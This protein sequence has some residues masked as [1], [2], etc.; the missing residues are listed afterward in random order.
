MFEGY[1]V[2]NASISN[3]IEDRLSDYMS[4]QYRA[5]LV[6][7]G[8]E[9]D[10]CSALTD[11]DHLDS[12]TGS[13][14]IEHHLHVGGT[15]CT[16][17]LNIETINV[18]QF[19]NSDSALNLNSNGISLY[20]G[21][22]NFITISQSNIAL[23]AGSNIID[24]SS[25]SISVTGNTIFNSPIKMAGPNE[26]YWWEQYVDYQSNVS[27][28][29]VFRSKGG[30]MVTFNDDFYPE[31]LNF[32]GKH[33]CVLKN[34]NI[35][36]EIKEYIGKIVCSSGDYSN[37][38]GESTIEIDEAIPVVE[39]SKTRM[40]KKIFG[41]IAGIDRQGCFRI[42]NIQ[43]KNNNI[44]PRVI[45]QSSGEGCIW[46]TNINGVFENGDLITTSFVPGLGARQDDG[47]VMNYTIGK[48][49]SDCNFDLHGI[50]FKFK[51]KTYKKQFVGCVYFL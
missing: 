33:R 41:V 7:S 1:S 36:K 11:P 37:L 26:D 48:I 21:G 42:G 10:N 32:T 17:A 40:D 31:V 51:T 35:E 18:S 45:I 6:T 29:L 46:V 50:E 30:M 8:T 22:S 2:N 49:T 16:R 24:I 44:L 28:D 27:A 23:I 4:N 14:S 25:N 12:F 19:T 13:V 39:I 34:Y 15:I 3:Y 38:Y 43:F 20:S 5:L 47:I 9:F